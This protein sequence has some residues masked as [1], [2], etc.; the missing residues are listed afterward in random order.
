MFIPGEATRRRFHWISLQKEF[1][2]LKR[3][4]RHPRQ[5]IAYAEAQRG[6]RSSSVFRRV[7]TDR[8]GGRQNWISILKECT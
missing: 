1:D 4:R 3:G 8:G 7:R 5:G 6:A 2:R